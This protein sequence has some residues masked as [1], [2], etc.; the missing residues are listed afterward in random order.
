MKNHRRD[1]M[2]T[3]A[4][5]LASTLASLAVLVLTTLSPPASAGTATAN[6]GVSVTVDSSCTISTAAVGFPNYQPI[7]ANLSTPDDSTSGSVTITCT[8]G[9]TSTIG[10]GL[11]NYSSSG[12]ARMT[13]G[14][15]TFINYN[16]YQ[17]AGRLNPWTNASPTW[18]TVPA[19]P[20]TAPRTYPVYARIPPGQ[21]GNGSYSDTVVATVNF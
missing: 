17:D 12:Q 14:V 20:S 10:L 1:T 2:K 16:L 21:S 6:L 9:T 11:G 5:I 8:T 18:M 15:S 19:A 13:D 3:L 7:G 4:T